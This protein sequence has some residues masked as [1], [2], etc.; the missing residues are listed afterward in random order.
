MS[1]GYSPP[2]I[3]PVRLNYTPGSSG[4][5]TRGGSRQQAQLSRSFLL[6]NMLPMT[7]PMWQMP[8][9]SADMLHLSTLSAARTFQGQAF[10]PLAT[11]T[12]PSASSISPGSSVFS[13]QSLYP[14]TS[15]PSTC[16]TR[17]HS[18]SSTSTVGTH[19]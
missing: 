14:V 9:T 18:S 6:Q 3:P 17:A 2:T 15:S 1:F 12:F 8:S 13:H 5:T 10:P 4:M 19:G 16:A 11:P 7:S